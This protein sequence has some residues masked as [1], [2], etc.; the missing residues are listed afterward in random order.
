MKEYLLSDRI[1]LYRY[2]YS[3]RYQESWVLTFTIVIIYIYIQIQVYVCVYYLLK[4]PFNHLLFDD[5]QAQCW[6]M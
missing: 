6:T 1:I 3:K 5:I 4:Q 2:H